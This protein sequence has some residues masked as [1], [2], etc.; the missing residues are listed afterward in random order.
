MVDGV[1]A[2]VAVPGLFLVALTIVA[3]VIRTSDVK[4]RDP[5]RRFSRQQRR[6]GMARAGGPVRDEVRTPPA[7]P[8]A[9]RP[10]KKV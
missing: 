9:R 10:R 2:S 8:G 1:L 5:V 6:E 3:A 4:R 7:V